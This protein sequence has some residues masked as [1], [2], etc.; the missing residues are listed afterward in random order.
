MRI[1][2]CHEARDGGRVGTQRN[3][4]HCG[5]DPA[6]TALPRPPIGWPV[7]LALRLPICL[8]SYSWGVTPW[9]RARVLFFS[10]PLSCPGGGDCIPTAAH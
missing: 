2:R 9:P 1:L 5:G 7:P 8:E 3:P 4:W 6:Q 10:H